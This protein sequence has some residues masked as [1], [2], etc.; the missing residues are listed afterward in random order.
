MSRQGSTLVIKP[1]ARLVVCVVFSSLTPAHGQSTEPIGHWRLDAGSGDVTSDASGQGH[2]GTIE[3]AKWVEAAEGHALGFDGED[4]RV[5]F[6][7][8][9]F[10]LTEAV[11]LSAW[12]RPDRVPERHAGVAGKD[13]A[14]FAMSFYRNRRVY[15]FIYAGSNKVSAPIAL[16]RWSHVAGT[17]DGRTLRL[18]VN[19]EPVA[20]AE[21][22]SPRFDPGGRFMI[23]R[24]VSRPEYPSVTTFPGRI[25]EVR[26]YETA[27]SGEAIAGLYERERAGYEREAMAMSTQWEA[28]PGSVR[29]EAAPVGLAGGG[30]G[31]ETT[32]EHAR[33]YE[34]E[35]RND[36]GAVLRVR[37]LPPS[38]RK[39]R[40][41]R[42]LREDET[43]G[44]S[45]FMLRYRAE[46]LRRSMHPY[47]IV[48]LE[49]SGD[50]VTALDCTQVINDGLEHVVVGLIPDGQALRRVTAELST[51]G[52]EAYLD[53]IEIRLID[54]LPPFVRQ[55][56][57]DGSPFR[58][59]D[60]SPRDDV[61]LA[62]AIRR[63]IESHGTI[64]DPF[65]SF[66]GPVE[67]VIRPEHDN[68]INEQRLE[69][70]G[71][72]IERKHV[73]PVSRSDTIDVAVNAGVSEVLLLLL[74]EAPPTSGHYMMPTTPLRLSDIE[75]F[76]V[77]LVYNDGR[78]DWAFPYSIADE[79]YV[80]GRGLGVYAVAA[81]PSRTL[82]EV[83]LH[84][85]WWGINVGLAGFAVNRSD[86]RE[87]PHLV[88][89]PPP[90][91]V[92]V[93]DLADPA[94]P[95]IERE[96]RTVRLRA[97]GVDMN[98]DLSDGLG[99]TSLTGA[100]DPIHPAS[101]LEIEHEGRVYT[102]LDFDVQDVRVDEREL[103]VDLRSR[104]DGLPIDV[105]LTIAA[106][107]D[108]AVFDGSVVNRGDA[109]LS[110]AFRAPVIRGLVIGGLEDT[111]LFFPKYRNEL[112]NRHGTHISPN[113][114]AFPLQFFDVFNPELGRGVAMQT[115]NLSHA[116]LRYRLAKSD[117]GVTAS[118]E[119][120]RENYVIGPGDTMELVETTVAA[121]PGGW[122]EA[123]DRYQQWRATW[124]EYRQ[125]EERD[126]FDRTFLLRTIYLGENS[127]Q[128]IVKAPPWY[129]GEP[130]RFRVEEALE[131]IERYWGTRP[132]MVH[133][134][135]WF[136][137]ERGERWSWGD[138]EYTDF[139][140]GGLP[141]FRELL[142]TLER[143]HGVHTSLYTLSDRASKGSR[144]GAKLAERAIRRKA[145][146][147]P[148]E[149]DYAWYMDPANPLWRDYYVQTLDRIVSDTGVDSIYLDV[150]SFKDGHRS[151]NLRDGYRA[152]TWP[153]RATHN[154]IKQARQTLP[155]DVPM[156]SEYPLDDVASQYHD[157]NI[158]Y[159]Y[160][161]LHGHFTASHD[162]RER[163]R[164]VAEPYLNVYRFALPHLKQFC[165]PVGIEG[166][167]NPSRLRM[168]FFN[169]EAL[170]D[171]TFRLYADRLRRWIGRGVEVQR[172]YADCFSSR[173]VTMLTP[174][175]RHG[176][177]ANRFD[178]D[179]R[180]AW[181]LYNGRFR[182][183]RGEL[184]AIA[185]VEG[186]TY[187]DAWRDEPLDPRI[188]HGKAYIELTLDP[189][190]CGAVVQH[191]PA[192][193]RP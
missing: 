2:D 10:P 104:I 87:Y 113:Q 15:W 128:R 66:P 191:R 34:V 112:S 176:V 27:L 165:F 71:T 144:V 98:V 45:W 74:T 175:R 174:T 83:R 178:G 7:E 91:R 67:G 123:L 75:A 6:E 8:K 111:W 12:L 167:R 46:G 20:K 14:R 177:Y 17:F 126:W 131:A 9:E 150:F 122:R 161:T 145:D 68:S 182:T 25:D 155:S 114:S 185:H 106:E 50:G 183:I 13:F 162:V 5:V 172:E 95:S 117:A 181:T 33:G 101:G 24:F 134:A 22:Q 90:R 57:A 62:G 64:T 35:S 32:V 171:S 37:G 158:A 40:W 100:G 124:Y 166:D 1:L 63:L 184:L 127:A 11:T 42:A 137:N 169:G 43:R 154:M 88:A 18:Y 143:E 49:G 120:P 164:R 89:E 99:L 140:V 70:F 139:A 97:G 132:D 188:E 76:A 109:P 72:E 4:D 136:S 44:T 93:A 146:G 82:A 153:N 110:L 51:T 55:G 186:A 148:V 173:D 28:S 138:Y 105:N 168:I 121:H 129:T 152:P 60:L 142:G 29:R 108:E 69:L 61:P 52:H 147:S 103:T 56:D 81:D 80:I 3:G 133:A 179:G 38:E 159:Y 119:Y 125:A 193:E 41:R 115:R 180:T 151:Y 187:H 78:R 189:Q 31:G 84:N 58:L 47:P 36:G 163:A 39:M 54:D 160:L 23:G 192:S 59:Y 130:G 19:G 102:G 30:Q 107:D 118:I 86:E 94:P 73:L 135:A 156:W 65:A 26:L 157:G 116:P 96:G 92:A 85:R 190:A 16:E 141:S 48:R 170:Y 21:S 149:T 79:G 77:E 53:L